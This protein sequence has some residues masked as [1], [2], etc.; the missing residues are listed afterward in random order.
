MEDRPNYWAVLPAQ[1]RYDK[2]LPPNAKLLYAEISAL[3]NGEGYCFASNAYFEG[4]YELSER[5][6][7]RLIRA[8]EAGGYIRIADGNG[9]KEQRKIYAGLNPLRPPD[10]NVSTPLS[11]MS[12]PPDKNVSHNKINNNTL[13]PVVPQGG[14]PPEKKRR[15][16]S[17]PDWKPERFEAF[18]R[19]YPPVN[20]KR[21]CRQRAVR[22]WDKLRPDDETI[23]RM[24]CALIRDLKSEM[25]QAGVG[26]PY[27][28]SWLNGRRWEDEVVPE[29]GTQRSGGGWAE[30]REVF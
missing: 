25:W 28:S 17:E 14:R 26:I 1:I 3:T 29:A 21:P 13:P 2:E 7:I 20:G 11:E 30:S 9:G 15:D 18:W 6:V 4:L 24:G 5:T 27:A 16:K 23:A 12:G 8:L 22:A 10:K 19:F